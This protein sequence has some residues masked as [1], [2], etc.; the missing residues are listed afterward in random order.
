MPDDATP[1]R[2]PRCGGGFACGAAGPAPCPCAGIALAPDLLASLR[3]RYPGCLCL[4]CLRAL[5]AGAPVDR[6]RR[7]TP[8]PAGPAAL[9]A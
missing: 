2:C 7:E 9:T 5:A 3:E 6:P 1:D 8:G 4:D